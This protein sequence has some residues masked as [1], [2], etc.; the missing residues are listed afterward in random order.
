[1]YI[2]FFDYYSFCLYIHCGNCHGKPTV[3]A[4]VLQK[5][6]TLTDGNIQA[7]ENETKTYALTLL[8]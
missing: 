2:S 7:V 1:M 8:V 3:I 6:V 4:S 5:N